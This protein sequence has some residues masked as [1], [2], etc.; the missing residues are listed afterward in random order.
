M[1]FLAKAIHCHVYVS[2]CINNTNI[3]LIFPTEDEEGKVFGYGLG[4]LGLLLHCSYQGM[5]AAGTVMFPVRVNVLSTACM[6]NEHR[7]KDNVGL[8]K[9]LGVVCSCESTW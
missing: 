5:N 7:P 2:A 9:R 6:I 1:L 3:S 8:F 4:H